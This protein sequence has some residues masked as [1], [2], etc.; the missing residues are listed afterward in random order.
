MKF[1][2]PQ[3]EVPSEEKKESLYDP[4]LEDL[5]DEYNFPGKPPKKDSGA[6]KSLLDKCSLYAV[7]MDGQAHTLH[8]NQTYD[9]Q[10]RILHN[11]IAI[12]V[13]GQKRSGMKASLAEDVAN[14]AYEYAR[15]VTLKESQ[16]FKAS[17]AKGSQ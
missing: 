13:V 17:A 12:M 1:E 14:F 6:E 16:E 10:R 7:Y 4:R 15:G 9:T 8:E 3:Q 11:E 5:W 2:A